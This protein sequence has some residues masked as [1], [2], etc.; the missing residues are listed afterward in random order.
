ML[1]ANVSVFISR[2]RRHTRFDCDWSSDVCSS[3][4][5]GRRSAGMLEK[6]GNAQA[7]ILA[8][9]PGFGPPRAEARLVAQGQHLLEDR[10]E[11][12][13][14]VDG[15][16]RRGIGDRRGRNEIAPAQLDRVDAADA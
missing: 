4:L 16:D 12:P 6:A 2:R 3:D 5:F 1:A 9:L 7:P 8:A 10:R 15:A 13:T 11:I 14:V